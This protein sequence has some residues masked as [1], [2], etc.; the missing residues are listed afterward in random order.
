MRTASASETTKARCLARRFRIAAAIVLALGMAAAGAVYWLGTRTPNLNNDPSMQGFNRAEM[1]QM[2][3]LYGKQG[4][5]IETWMN[6]LKEPATQAGIIA[7]TTVI[8]AA[9]CFYFARLFD[10]TGVAD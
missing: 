4:E 10:E 6:D 3:Q 2:G 5:L 1:R 8:I 7:A 9:G